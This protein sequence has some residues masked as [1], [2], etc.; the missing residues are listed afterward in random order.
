MPMPGRVEAAA[1]SGG[2][3][4]PL[5]RF[6]YW[7]H[8]AAPHDQEQRPMNTQ[9]IPITTEPRTDSPGGVPAGAGVWQ[10]LATG[11]LEPGEPERGFPQRAARVRS[12][13]N[14]VDA[15]LQAPRHAGAARSGPA[16]AGRA[17]RP[18]NADFQG[19]A[20]AGRAG[21]RRAGVKNLF[22]IHA[23]R[24]ENP[25]A[26]GHCRHHRPGQLGRLLHLPAPWQRGARG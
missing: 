18:A 24:G 3:D 4:A 8:R 9:H 23:S 14:N 21:E 20:T 12:A 15:D 25:D 22:G 1:G 16:R 5:H 19:A 6:R 13:Y 7:R 11:L 2:W 10:P 17:P 26:S